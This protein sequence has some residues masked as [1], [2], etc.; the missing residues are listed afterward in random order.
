MSREPTIVL[1]NGNGST[2]VFL[3]NKGNTLVYTKVNNMFNALSGASEG[4]EEVDDD[5][6]VFSE[7]EECL[8]ID[9][10]RRDVLNPTLNA[11]S[12][13]RVTRSKTNRKDIVSKKRPQQRNKEPVLEK[14]KMA[15]TRGRGGGK[16]RRRG[17]PKGL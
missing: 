13:P 11:S 6:S 14:G 5:S 8:S 10:F 4:I 1:L 2:T 3:N 17:R 9:H 7:G 15:T 12:E 16:G